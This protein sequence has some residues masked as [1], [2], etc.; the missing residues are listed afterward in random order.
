[1]LRDCMRSLTNC[2]CILRHICMNMLCV[3]VVVC[4]C[5]VARVRCVVICR[6]AR[7]IVRNTHATHTQPTTTTH[8]TTHTTHNRHNTHNTHAQQQTQHHTHKPHTQPTHTTHAHA[9]THT[10]RNIHNNNAHTR[11][12]TDVC[13]SRA[14]QFTQL[15]HTCGMCTNQCLCHIMYVTLC[16]RYVICVAHARV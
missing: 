16:C 3:C 10:Q 15:Y 14:C 11:A 4:C 8:T 6:Y 7:N 2:L 13:N 9:T 5:D 12:T 1:M